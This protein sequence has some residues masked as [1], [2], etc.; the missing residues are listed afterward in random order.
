M[1][2]INHPHITARKKLQSTDWVYASGQCA[3]HF[4][5]DEGTKPCGTD[6]EGIQ[7]PTHS[8]IDCGFWT[9]RQKRCTTRNPEEC[10]VGLSSV[11]RDP[12]ESIMWDV[13]P[14][15]VKCTYAL[16]D[17]DTAEQLAEFRTKFPADKGYDDLMTKFCLA[18][19]VRNCPA[20]FQPD[21]GCSR[22][23]A[24]DKEGEECRT[25]MAGKSRDEQ[26]AHMRTYCLRNDTEDC[27]CINRTI[28]DPEYDRLK[29]HLGG[30]ISDNCW[31]KPCSNAES[32]FLVPHRL[33]SQPCES[34]VCQQ[35]IEAHATGTVD[36]S[37]NR[38]VINCDFG[39][40]RTRSGREDYD[41]DDERAYRRA[42]DGKAYRRRFSDLSLIALCGL[43]LITAFVVKSL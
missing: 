40:G 11:G 27:K 26:D 42:R 8:F 1:L 34:N 36:I 35:I 25:W 4:Y 30:A 7:D 28:D 15:D 19:V 37:G 21:S 18:R 9:S 3:K 5:S 32:V 39:D 33:S 13:A 22:L 29:T 41:E 43:A 14:P 24:H 12:F 6:A 16:N 38:E 31:Y 2:H 20:S 10:F 17:I 23:V